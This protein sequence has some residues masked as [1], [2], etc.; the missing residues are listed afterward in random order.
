M[1]HVAPPAGPVPSANDDLVEALRRE[2]GGLREEME[3]LGD[4]VTEEDLQ[5]L[6]RWVEGIEGMVRA[7][8]LLADMTPESVARVLRSA[9]SMA[10]SGR[11]AAAAASLRQVVAALSS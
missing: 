8:A 3:K 1:P 9:S 4:S 2:L 11:A 7:A 5:A 6:A 10:A